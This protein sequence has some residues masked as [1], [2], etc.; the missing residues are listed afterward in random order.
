MLLKDGVYQVDSKEFE[1]QVG[2]M[3][4]YIPE[5]ITL[6]YRNIKDENG[7]E[8]T[9]ESSNATVDTWN[10]ICKNVSE[11]LKEEKYDALIIIHGTDTLTY[12]ASA[13][14]FGISKPKVPIIITASQYPISKGFISD[15]PSNFL[16]SIFCAQELSI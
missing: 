15:G 10:L 14:T 6:E 16:G 7:K 4:Q 9:I 11:I 13:L 3:K 8:K 2:K 1:L 12:T 5:N